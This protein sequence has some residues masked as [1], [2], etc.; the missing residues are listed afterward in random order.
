MQTNTEQAG[1]GDTVTFTI[2]ATDYAGN[3]VTAELG[4]GLT[5]LAVLTLAPS[6]A[7]DLIAYFY[8]QQGLSVRT[9]TPLS[10]NTDQLTQTVLDVIKGGG[11]GFGEGGIFDIRQEFVDT[12]YWNGSLTTN[13]DGTASFDVTLP[14]NLTTWRLDV[15]AVTSGEDGN[16]L[17]GATT[18]DLISTKPLL[19][20]PVTPRFFVVGD[21][22]TLAAMVNNNTE[23]EQTVTVNLSGTGL[24]LPEDAAQTVTIPAGAGQRVEWS[25][26]VEN[27]ESV[28]LL[29][30][31]QNADGSLTDASKPPL[32]QGEEHLLPVYRYE[33]PETV[34][35]GGAL[36]DAGS[37]TETILLP[38][39][40]PVVQG[41]L[42]VRVEPSLVATTFASLRAL[43]LGEYESVEQTITYLFANT[44]A[45]RA[46][47]GTPQM[48]DAL[49]QQLSEQ[50]G[51]SLQRMYAWQKVDGGWGWFARDDS[52]PGMTAYA[53]LGL[54]EA[55]DQ[56]FMVSDNV[57][58][59]AVNFLNTRFIIPSV[60]VPQWQ[61]NRQSLMLYALAQA[62]AADVAR[63]ANLYE[64]R[65]MLST[66]A[67][68]LLALTVAAIDGGNTRADVLISDLVS[69]AVISATGVHWEETAP[70]R[71]NWNTNTRTTAM[72]LDALVRLTPQSELIPNVIRWL[73][74]ARKADAWETTQET[75]WATLALTDWSINTGDTTPSY[76]YAIDLN[77]TALAA[78][79]APA[80]PSVPLVDTAIDIDAL[81]ASNAL[82][83]SREAGNGALYYTAFLRA[84]LPVDQV[85][86]LNNGVVIERRYTLLGDD[87]GTPI[88]Q[89]RVGDQIQVRLTII[90]PNDLNFIIITDPIPA[91]TDAIN[92]DLATSPQVGTQPELSR[93]NPLDQGW[94]WWWF[95]NIEFRDQQV[96]LYSSYL[97]AGTYEFV[98]TIRAGLEGVYNVI[99]ATAQEAYF[100]EVY[101]RS[102]G[103]VFT[104]LSGE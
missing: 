27:T 3:P 1:P 48:T 96:N 91:G 81:T 85:D 28:D 26:T 19:I 65:A 93:E 12:A 43:R 31:V 13:A 84:Y 57:V 54:V 42:R 77:G 10:I 36:L 21:Q 11:G 39:S 87:S 2:R 86:P 103:M 75:A 68:A 97:P 78:G 52:D 15:R 47:N 95:S 22:A 6:N 4:A 70:D 20:R 18:Y 50:I 8:G 104:I 56:G 90:A 94:G 37:V 71:Y 63:T 24:T 102:A 49:R 41:D 76:P 33:V 88:T 83:I 16:M 89:A 40:L 59:N 5:D 92:P 55:R 44:E 46:V 30:T 14:D 79:S 38:T 73:M 82:T 67:K 101:G 34:G 9:A 72:V 80:D 62:N 25:A 66:W 98:Y 45:F 17:V 51:M 69:S 7:S 58:Q 23:T 100:P 64:N 53:L 60:S 29:F 32:G 35:T 99:P 61:I 74:A